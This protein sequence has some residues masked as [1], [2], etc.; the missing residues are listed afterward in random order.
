MI[1]ALTINIPKMVENS[2]VYCVYS[3]EQI[4]PLLRQRY[5]LLLKDDFFNDYVKSHDATGTH[6]PMV[7]KKSTTPHMNEQHIRY[8]FSNMKNTKDDGILTLFHQY[9]T[10]GFV[11]LEDDRFKFLVYVGNDDRDYQRWIMNATET[12][13][14]E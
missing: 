10:R 14:I 8:L 5:E 3:H 6:T 12:G 9:Q 4:A 13:E 2:N 1:P 11:V 7:V